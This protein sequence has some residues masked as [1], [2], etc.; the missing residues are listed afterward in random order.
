LATLDE[1]ADAARRVM[2]SASVLR[3]TVQLFEFMNGIGLRGNRTDYTD[4]R[5]SFLNEVMDRGLGLPITLAIV[6]LE[7]AQRLEIA[8]EGVGLPGHFIVAICDEAGERYFFDPFNNGAALTRDDALALVRR[9][10]GFEGGVNEE[11]FASTTA[12]ALIARLLVNLRSNYI[13]K[14]MWAECL[15]VLAHLRVLQPEVAEHARDMALAYLRHNEPRSAV[16]ML[17]QYVTQKPN[18]SDIEPLRRAL[19][20]LIERLA[21]L[22]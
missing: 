6:F 17:E 3:R 15:V 7:L 18:A 13:Q 14:E 9:T 2:T 20:P 16:T 19:G 4:P 10:T 21:K 5:N 8:A 12:R 11:W 1:W 22:N